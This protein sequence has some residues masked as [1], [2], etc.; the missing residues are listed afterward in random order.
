MA[1]VS[2]ICKFWRTTW[3]TKFAYRSQK[4]PT[5]GIL[6]SVRL[7]RIR[8]GSRGPRDAVRLFYLCRLASLWRE[9]VS[10]MVDAFLASLAGRSG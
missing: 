2:W 9:L 3:L 1:E 7:E 10:R 6:S 8:G 5:S 4:T